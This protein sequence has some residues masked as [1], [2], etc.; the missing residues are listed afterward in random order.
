MRQGARLTGIV[1]V[2]PDC[3]LE[4][5]GWVG[6][7]DAPDLRADA[8]GRVWLCTRCIGTFWPTAA[9]GAR[10]QAVGQTTLDLGGDAA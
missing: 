3:E 2:S 8:E 4:A 9:R 1:C 5:C 7:D 10:P 6:A